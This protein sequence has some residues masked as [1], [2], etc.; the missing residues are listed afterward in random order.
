MS[1]TTGHPCPASGIWQSRTCH[2]KQI[3]LSKGEVFPP[4]STCREAVTW[5]LVRK[6]QNE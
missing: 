2:P 6:T 3:A 4:C 5:V 1:G